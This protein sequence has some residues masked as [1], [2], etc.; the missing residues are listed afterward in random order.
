MKRA[1][2]S[3]ARSQ[4]ANKRQKTEVPD[5]HLTPCRTDDAGN[6]IWPVPDWQ[7]RN[8]RD[9]ISACANANERV[10]I[11]PDKDADGLTSGV[12]LY[13]TLKELGL[14][15]ENINVHFVTKGNVAASKEERQAMQATNP[16]YIFV[17]D[18]GS[19]SKTPLIDASHQGV[20][21]DH[22]HG[23]DEDFP[24]GSVFASACHYP[25]VATTS[26][27]TYIICSELSSTIT[28]DAKWLCAIGTHG[29]L[30]NTFKWER[31][32]PDMSDTFKQ[33][34]KAKINTAISLLN[35]PRRTATY[36]VSSAWEALVH[37]D[38]PDMILR[39]SRL[40]NAR[41]EV[42]GEV[43][44]CT[45]TPPR[46]SSDGRIAMF[47]ISSVAQVHPVIAT[48]WAGHLNSAKLEIVMVA[49][50]GYLPGKV[51]F[52]CRI[53]KCARLRE[54]PH[55]VN[56]IEILKEVAERDTTGTLMD[57]LGES[58]ARGHKE[59]SGGMVP[60]EAFDKFVTCLELAERKKKGDATKSPRK[61]SDS[62]KNT[63]MN[64]FQKQDQPVKSPTR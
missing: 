54:G 6:P 30:G 2:S 64:Y 31:P 14:N 20:V 33:Y 40:L 13:R 47:R 49:N 36:D 18:Q 42:N 9:A 3:K 44:R 4:N 28:S 29:D 59:A 46:F 22:H 57:E 7:L 26:L 62:Q 45:H 19:W 55:D 48:R 56:I 34:T 11:V 58:F 21:I 35:A 8:V 25:P 61:K 10:L 43:E 23:E 38:S 51:N 39:S 17:L 12:I 27:L 24:V 52:S 53:A 5:Y 60:T 37:A 63:L 50:E 41:A 15:E 16:K 32:F 1:A